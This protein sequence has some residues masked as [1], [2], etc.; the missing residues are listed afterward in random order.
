MRPAS[1]AE[2]AEAARRAEQRRAR[3]AST[4]PRLG[5]YPGVLGCLGFEGATADA[6][7]AAALAENLSE[8]WWAA[9]GGAK[10]EGA[11]A[12]VKEDKLVAGRATTTLR[13]TVVAS[14]DTLFTLSSR[15]K[16]APVKLS[17]G[18]LAAATHEGMGMQGGPDSTGG[19]LVYGSKGFDRGV[20]YWEVKVEEN[21]LR[22]MFV[23][24]ARE[25]SEMRTEP[26][27]VGF[28]LQ[29]DRCT[30][31]PHGMTPYGQ[32][33]KKGHIVGVLL[34][35]ERGVVSFTREGP[36][37]L[38]TNPPEAVN[39]GVAF[40]HVISDGTTHELGPR[41]RTKYFPVFGL[42]NIER[43]TLRDAKW[44]SASSAYPLASTSELL[45]TAHLMHLYVSPLVQPAGVTRAPR[46]AQA[47]SNPGR[48]SEP[49]VSD[50]ANGDEDEAAELARALALST[51]LSIPLSGT[52]LEEEA[53]YA[54]PSAAAVIA[55]KVAGPGAGFAA[56]VTGAADAG[57]A[58][59][60]GPT[61]TPET[62]AAALPAAALPAW[63]VDEAF[64][65][66]R[67]LF[68]GCRS[69]AT[70]AGTAVT[71]NPA[72]E[73]VE[74]CGGGEGLSPGDAVSIARGSAV[75]LGECGGK[76]WYKVEGEDVGAWFWSRREAQDQR[77]KSLKE[78]AKTAKLLAEGKAPVAKKTTW[79]WCVTRPRA[80]IA[81]APNRRRL[82]RVKPL[83]SS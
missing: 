6:L 33:F 22:G 60:A 81:P 57:A 18:L 79:S 26:W 71:V 53:S 41:A 25:S 12:K 34:D 55:G 39:M 11:A 54:A 30:Y 64:A 48:P 80:S 46:L 28:G 72:A 37:R 9:E 78:A 61:A 58:G 32:Y 13:G 52:P 17:D 56:A 44:W 68:T 7:D 16:G 77:K 45:R 83:L 73:A 10:E 14:A 43:F 75:V 4:V 69:H 62:P 24:V 47:P 67:Q 65:C 35:L 36:A 59:A 20:H 82:L 27:Q 40:K 21:G 2:V 29:S 74:R 63:F 76:L 66:W 31:C 50:G 1:P 42:N 5:A 51:S 23:G 15:F 38:T 49:V 19:W 8:K 3:L 70:R